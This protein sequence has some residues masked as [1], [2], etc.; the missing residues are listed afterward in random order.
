MSS[1]RMDPP[2]LV[3]LS[4]MGMLPLIGTL[5]NI[6]A[7]SFI[8][9]AAHY[10]EDSDTW[11]ILYPY[12]RPLLKADVPEITACALLDVV[13]EPVSDS[14]LALYET[15]RGLPNKQLPVSVLETARQWYM[16]NSKSPFWSAI[17][18]PGR[19]GSRS[20]AFRMSPQ[21]DMNLP[22]ANNDT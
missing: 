22:P 15:E 1:Q 8:A 19:T 7:A 13:S 10:L 5:G 3:R 18:L 16:A 4:W 6:A 9:I 12:I 2:R 21:A 11:C 14:R 17:L 20:K